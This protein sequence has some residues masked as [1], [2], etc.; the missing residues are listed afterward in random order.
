MP[1][2]RSSR[3][4][5]VR[6]LR[7]A[8]T[9]LAI[10]LAACAGGPAP[11]PLAGGAPPA[12]GGVARPPVTPLL[13]LPAGAIVALERCTVVVPAD[14][15]DVDTLVVDG[16]LREALRQSPF[17]DVAAGAERAP[18]P[19]VRVVPQVDAAARSLTLTA[20]TEA[21]AP[22]PLC[23]VGFADRP[24]AAA[25]D[26][27]A[28]L[29]RERLGER[30]A[31]PPAPVAQIYSASEPCVRALE[32]AQRDESRGL[33]DAGRERIDRAL[34]SDP[35]C[36][37]ALLAR[38]HAQ[39]D[40]Q[41]L[42]GAERTATQT[43]ALL[44]GR[45]SPT[46]RHRLARLLLLA[47]AGG[48]AARAERDRAARTDE[49]LLALGDVARRERPFDPHA[50]LTRGLA[51]TYLGRFADAADTL[52]ALRARWPDVPQIG[53][54][55]CF[56]ELG[57]GDA[58]AALDAIERE[59]R[60]LPSSR[61]LLPHALA[62]YHAG[63]HDDL[64]ELLERTEARTPSDSPLRHEALRMRAAH[65]ILAGDADAAATRLLEDLEW[66]R[67]RPSQLGLRADELVE[68]G[69]SLCE[70]GFTEALAR[71]L[72]AF[73]E[74][75]ELAAT[76]RLA[77][78]Y[79][80]GLCDVE[81]GGDVL[82]VAVATLEQA[83]ATA[84]AARLRGVA[85]QRH[86]DIAVAAR[87]LATALRLSDE[88]ITRARFAQ[89]LRQLGR[90]DEARALLAETRERLLALDLRR[91]L[92]HPLLAPGRALAWLAATAARDP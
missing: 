61:T 86:G 80:Q 40:A 35:G 82:A 29:A 68:A 57:V 89:L 87:E 53:Y 45:L 81:R 2:N 92:R 18:A 78:T 24:L 88:P 48:Q 26:D 75:P 84:R 50:E 44:D 64:A 21:S 72:P 27:A 46:T 37:L 14:G 55:L 22:L 8:G 20:A 47:R 9:A 73:A 49:Q 19:A 5:R 69:E 17:F 56:A 16:L 63:L 41:D 51:L 11:A 42:A 23:A 36:A 38:G 77:L 12:G 65:A 67:A 33:P 76:A 4:T 91:P 13:L 71:R 62:L 90:T 28:L 58:R 74:L 70:L 25:I 3:A 83:D 43:L 79:L 59:Q 39:L 66:L 52:R 34:R 10:A 60:R 15:R 31:E 85:A 32:E 30:P 6:P 54:H 1:P 7:L